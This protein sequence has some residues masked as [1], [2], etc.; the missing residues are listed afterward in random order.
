[1]AISLLDVNTMLLKILC[2]HTYANVVIRLKTTFFFLRDEHCLSSRA[3]NALD[4]KMRNYWF[5]IREFP[6][7]VHRTVRNESTYMIVQAYSED[8]IPYS[9]VETKG[10]CLLNLHELHYINC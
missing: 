3:S 2:L 6:D 5:P 8:A 9:A 1:M 10:F 4:A 7:L